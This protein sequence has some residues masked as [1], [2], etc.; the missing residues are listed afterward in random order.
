MQRLGAGSSFDEFA[1]ANPDR[2]SGRPSVR[3]LL[4]RP[5]TLASELARRKF[6]LPDRLASGERSRISRE[7]RM[8][9]SPR[10]V[11]VTEVGSGFAQ[12]IEAGGHVLMAD[13][14]VSA[15][16]T[17]TGPDPYALL[18][19]A[20]GSCTSMTIRLYARHKS[21]PLEGVSVRLRHERV[22]AKDCEDCVEK[23]DGHVE[24]ITRSIALSGALTEEQKA[25]LLEIAER[26]PVHRTLAA[27]VQ[28]ATQLS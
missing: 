25:R 4:Y 6:V 16:G 10:E 18:L 15:G 21:W 5:E 26:C 14:P 8:A 23:K 17:D 11:I 19:A 22:Y 13:E 7:V 27:P 28:I 3:D 20:L 9:H 2:P 12:R 1:R 24:R